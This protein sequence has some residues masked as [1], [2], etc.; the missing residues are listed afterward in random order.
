MF[1]YE[2]I[3]YTCTLVNLKLCICRII[4]FYYSNHIFSLPPL[5][6]CHINQSVTNW[7][8]QL[9]GE[10]LVKA[11]VSAYLPIPIADVNVICVLIYVE[12][13]AIKY[14]LN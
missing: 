3:E 2:T 11:E 1:I 12:H 4:S 5:H 9:K 14:L 6:V 10:G 13:E 8:P 7:L